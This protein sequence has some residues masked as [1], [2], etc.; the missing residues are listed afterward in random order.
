MNYSKFLLRNEIDL[1]G[2]TVAITGATGSLGRQ[3]ALFVAKSGGHLLFLDRNKAKSQKL[4]NEI[5]KISPLSQVNRIETDFSTCES[6]FNSSKALSQTHVDFL[7]LNA[8]VFNIPREVGVL[9][10]DKIF[11]VNY[12]MP[13]LLIRNLIPY[14]KKHKTKVIIIGSIAYKKSKFKTNDIDFTKEKSQIRVYG[15]SKRF[16]MF[17]LS[18]LFEKEGIDFAVA[19]PGITATNLTAHYPKWINW[20]IKGLMKCVFHSPKKGCMT[21]LIATKTKCEI[22]QWIGPKVF[23]VWG[24]PTKKNYN[25]NKEESEMMFKITENI[26]K[27]KI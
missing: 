6:I 17:S 3:T 1:N 7:V 12:L 15:N 4:K 22:G 8:G 5:L 9:G 14:L 25:F 26:I 18:S 23:G 24:K 13:Y 10:Y 21:I 19:H 20:L 11:E 2:K 27:M 16:L